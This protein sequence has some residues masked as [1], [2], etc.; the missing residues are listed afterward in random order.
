VSVT[1]QSSLAQII[2]IEKPQQVKVQQ[3]IKQAA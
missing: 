3:T 1:S 2:S